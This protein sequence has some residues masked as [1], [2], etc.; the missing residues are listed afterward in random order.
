[1]IQTNML[2][3]TSG[4]LSFIRW[5]KGKKWE[6]E[7]SSTTFSSP[8]KIN[9]GKIFKKTAKKIEFKWGAELNIRKSWG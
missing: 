7:R 5:W 4:P 9:E 2:T 3:F 1:M 8:K 6:K